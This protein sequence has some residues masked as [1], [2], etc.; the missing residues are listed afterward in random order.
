VV[1]GT[2]SW[3]SIFLWV[4]IPFPG[5]KGL[6][7]PSNRHKGHH[8]QGEAEREAKE[9]PAL[10]LSP[11]RET[12]LNKVFQFSCPWQHSQIGILLSSGPSWSWSQK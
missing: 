8:K 12:R 3:A 5:T 11:L 7:I 2:C 9:R 10:F 4:L 1:F 6:L